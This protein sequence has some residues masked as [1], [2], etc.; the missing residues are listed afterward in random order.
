MSNNMK[1]ALIAAALLAYWYR[2]S[3]LSAFFS[4]KDDCGDG[5]CRDKYGNC[6]L[7]TNGNGCVPGASVRP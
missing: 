6:V 4:K 2:D 3:L 5:W 7:A 1:L